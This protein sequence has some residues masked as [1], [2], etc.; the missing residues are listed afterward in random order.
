MALL[1]AR[2]ESRH[3]AT[4]RLGFPDHAANPLSGP[5]EVSAVGH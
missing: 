2:E 1:T 4:V 3:S 5:I